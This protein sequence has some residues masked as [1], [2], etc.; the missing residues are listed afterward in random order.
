MLVIL[1]KVLTL[2]NLSSPSTD[3]YALIKSR[4]EGA[5]LQLLKFTEEGLVSSFN[6][7]TGVG[8]P[9][10]F[11]K[12]TPE[13]NAQFPD[14]HSE[15]TVKLIAGMRDVLGEAA[16][17]KVIDVTEQAGKERYFQELSPLSDLEERIAKLAEIR[18][19]EGYMAEYTK[20]E[21]GYLLVENHCP[22]C[23]AA[24]TCQGFCTAELNVFKFVLGESVSID[25]MDHIVS[26]DRRCAYR[27][28]KIQD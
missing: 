4:N 28:A 20:D 26:G 3:N 14:T 9:K 1:T 10:Q 7:S 11:F 23:A 15:L 22:I 18:T 5:R 2:P 13:G 16:L 25:R 17:Q 6:E 21:S 24:K 19:R 12:L 8:R 27:I